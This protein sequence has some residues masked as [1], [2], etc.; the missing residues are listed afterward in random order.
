M[1]C[2][3]PA[4]AG[5][6]LRG[7]ANDVLGLDYLD[8]RHLVATVQGVVLGGGSRTFLGAP[9]GA[10]IFHAFDGI[11]PDDVRVV[12]L[13]QDPYPSPDFSTGRDFEAGNVADWR[14]L[15]K[16]F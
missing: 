16:M 1:L 11:R 10:H 13:G 3:R 2:D 4:V 5:V 9:K 8:A 14:E 12:V 15:E 6:E 7:G